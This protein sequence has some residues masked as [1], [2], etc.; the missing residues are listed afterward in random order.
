MGAHVDQGLAGRRARARHPQP[1]DYLATDIGPES[2]LV[3]RQSDGSVRAFYNVCQHRGNRLRPCG[4]GSSGSSL[5]FKCLYHHWE[6]NLDGSYRR[7]PD[8]DTFPQGRASLRDD[9][10][11]V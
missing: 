4:R 1:G 8:I 2:I 3:V 7:I 11:Q 9:G 10:D 5:S 6:Y